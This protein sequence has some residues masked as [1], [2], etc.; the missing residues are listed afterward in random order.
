[1]AVELMVV[2][3][4]ELLVVVVIIIVCVLS[5]SRGV[6]SLSNGDRIREPAN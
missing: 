5:A 6:R 4:A 3:A 2:A 1:M